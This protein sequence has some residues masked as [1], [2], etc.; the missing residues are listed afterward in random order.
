MTT[1]RVIVFFTAFLSL[2]SCSSSRLYNWG[3]Y[4]DTIYKMYMEPGN[5]ALPD[6]IQQLEAQI[7]RT[8]ASDSRVPPGLHAHLALLYIS[9]GD[10]P[11][12]KVHLVA[13]KTKFPESKH[14][15]DGMIARM[16]KQ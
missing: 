15:I 4:E 7:E 5:A 13:E 12:A 10:Y 6:E 16:E 8:E 2:C 9:Q 14:F 11:T 3:S 1:L